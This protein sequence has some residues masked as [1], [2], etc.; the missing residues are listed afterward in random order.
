VRRLVVFA[1]VVTS[2]LIGNRRAF[3]TCGDYLLHGP[4]GSALHG[5]AGLAPGGGNDLDR[6][7][8][9]GSIV[10][11]NPAWLSYFP[12]SDSLPTESPS[13]C[14]GGRCQSAPPPSPMH[15]PGRIILWKQL[16]TVLRESVSDRDIESCGWLFPADGVCPS[17]PS[18]SVEVPPPERACSHV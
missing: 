15:L 11:D 3:A 12:G 17:S 18:L 2:L 10:W 5:G 9:L 7:S 1:I 13:P 16:A 4:M 8:G 6:L 14:A